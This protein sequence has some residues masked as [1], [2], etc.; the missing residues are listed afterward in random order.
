MNCQC[1]TMTRG[2]KAHGERA[3]T[4]LTLGSTT[5]ERF[6]SIPGRLTMIFRMKRPEVSH[7]FRTPARSGSRGNNSFA[8]AGGFP[9]EITPR[10]FAWQS[11][12]G[13]HMLTER[14]IEQFRNPDI[15]TDMLSEV[16]GNNPRIRRRKTEYVSEENDCLGPLR[17]ITWCWGKVV[18]VNHGALWLTRDDETLVA[19]CASH[20]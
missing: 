15:Y 7:D 6:A 17:S 2:V 13:A 8:S 18:A 14:T 5:E 20:E 16:G 4:F 11:P 12:K 19:R 10:G 3:H 1:S 9:K